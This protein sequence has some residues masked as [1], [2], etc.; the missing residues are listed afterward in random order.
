MTTQ[1]QDTGCNKNPLKP[2]Q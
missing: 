2:K 1:L